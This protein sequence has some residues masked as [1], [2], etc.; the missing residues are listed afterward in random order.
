[1]SGRGAAGHL[2][3]SAEMLVVL[4][5]YAFVPEKSASAPAVG[6]DPRMDVVLSGY[7]MNVPA[8][9]SLF[10]FLS[11]ERFHDDGGGTSG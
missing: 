10:V 9:E 1:M 8:R 2:A 6:R 4:T 3:V 11:R 7:W 5:R